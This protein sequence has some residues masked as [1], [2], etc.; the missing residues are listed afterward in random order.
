MGVVGG[1]GGSWGCKK[2]FFLFLPFGTMSFWSQE[3]VSSVQAFTVKS[4]FPL[5]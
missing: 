1:S 2:G 4:K 5:I 3:R